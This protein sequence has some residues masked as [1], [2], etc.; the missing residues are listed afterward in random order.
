M[1]MKQGL[2]ALTALS[3]MLYGEV[4]AQDLKIGVI[5]VF[6]GPQAVLGGQ[7]RD[8]VNLGLK[9]VGGKLGGLVTTVIVQ[10]DELKPDVAVGKAKQLI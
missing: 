7:L 8:G 9:H 3:G 4:L 6:S 2:V 10:D 1:A 5:A